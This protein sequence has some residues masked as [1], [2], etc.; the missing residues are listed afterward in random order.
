MSYS[1]QKM[2]QVSFLPCESHCQVYIIL[3]CLF[4]Y[5]L[6]LAKFQQA[7]IT[8]IEYI[9]TFVYDFLQMRRDGCFNPCLRKRSLQIS[10]TELSAQEQHTDSSRFWHMHCRW[11][12]QHLLNR[13]W[14]V[15]QIVSISHKKFLRL[16]QRPLVQTADRKHKFFWPPSCADSS[17][18]QFSALA[19]IDMWRLPL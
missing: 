10:R 3:L 6:P 18:Q 15:H 12:L 4:H 16:L 17:L 13:Q 5:A 9:S 19:M 14:S 8:G 2:P 7:V 11:L 1:P